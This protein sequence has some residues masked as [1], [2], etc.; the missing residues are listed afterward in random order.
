[1]TGDGVFVIECR[2]PTAPARPGHQFID[3]ERLEVD[4]IG[5]T[6]VAVQLE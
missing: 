5:A 3:V 2:V 6:R 4:H 1:L